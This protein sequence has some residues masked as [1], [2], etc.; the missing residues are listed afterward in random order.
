MPTFKNLTLN[1]A[2]KIIG[3][4]R[5]ADAVVSQAYY[6]G[7]AWQGG[8]AWVGPRPAEGE[9]EAAGVMAEI[10]AGLVS[11]NVI[12]ECVHRHRDALIGQ[13]PD[14]SLVPRR[15]LGRTPDPEN[16]E[17]TLPG[18]PT[19]EEKRLI[20]EANAAL[21][22]WWDGQ[23]ALT[24][25]QE[26][27][28]NLLISSY[29]KSLTSKDARACLRL[30]VPPA[31]LAKSGV[32]PLQG[33]LP[34]A[35]NLIYPHAPELFTATVYVDP[36]SQE[37]M[38]MYAFVVSDLAGGAEENRVEV[39]GLNDSRQTIIRVY[40]N[41]ETMAET[42]PLDL[43][44]H[45]GIFEMRRERLITP[46]IQQLQALCNMALTMMGRNVVLGGFLERVILN[47][48]M[49]GKFID[50]PENPGKKIFQPHPY[51]VGPS[52]TNTLAGLPIYG[53]PQRRDLIT[54][55]TSPDVVYRDPVDVSTF[56]ET[57]AEAYGAV[58]DQTKQT[59][60]LISK[61]ATASGESRKQAAAEFLKSLN[62]TK[63]Q[64]E[65][66]GRWLLETALAMAAQF[67]GQ[68]GRFAGLRAQ[69]QCRVD[70]GPMTSEEQNTVISLKRESII[71]TST[72]MQ[73]AGVDDPEAEIAK[74][75]KERAEA[76][77]RTVNNAKAM[78]A[79]K[80]PEPGNP[81]DPPQ[82]PQEP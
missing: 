61:D 34:D 81:N 56:K 38:G 67:T 49:P 60:A 71:S 14:W 8:S 77:A 75:A 53:D 43:G 36:N 69:F 57:L 4:L 35:L 7:D 70:I 1:D 19:D 16:P 30:F 74:I 28:S 29:P 15:P 42:A 72:A 62:S 39:H 46:Q 45:L 40:Q 3:L 18:E 6:G 68:P 66:A 23:Q 11:K 25:I 80:Q 22:D 2:K 50:D 24:L 82:P 79:I 27:A 26:A 32:V 13:E 52:A 78:A 65:A 37:R 9:A 17:R 21:V 54:G 5:D 63:A 44:G 48:Q 10:E 31:S 64:I 58:L 47:A 12:A 76:D 33:S 59:H 55:Y 73:R 20:D 41:A 51:K